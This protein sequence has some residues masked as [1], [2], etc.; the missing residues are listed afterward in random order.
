MPVIQSK[1]TC[2]DFCVGDHFNYTKYLKV[3][4]HSFISEKVGKI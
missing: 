3:I 2:S 4:G 1:M